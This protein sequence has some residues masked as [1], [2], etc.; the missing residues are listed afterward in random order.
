LSVP[1]SLRSITTL[2]VGVKIGARLFF[3]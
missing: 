3:I 2:V 1:Y